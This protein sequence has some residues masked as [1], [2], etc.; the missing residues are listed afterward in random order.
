MRKC[1]KKSEIVDQLL[2][3]VT[4]AQ[5]ILIV[6]S[7]IYPLDFINYV[8]YVM[9]YVIGFL[10][11]LSLAEKSIAKHFLPIAFLGCFMLFLMGQKPFKSDYDAFLTFT[12]A[13]L[14]TE[15]YVTFASILFFGLAGMYYSYMCFSGREN[16]R[17]REFTAVNKVVLERIL[18]FFLI[19]TFPFA[20]YMQTKIVLVKS[21]MDYTAGYLVN[22]EVPTA[23]KIGSYLYEAVVLMYLAMKPKKTRMFFA[24][25][26]YL[27][28]TG[29]LQLLQGRRALFAATL[30]FTMWYLLKYFN[31]QKINK[32]TFFVLTSLVA[33]MVVIFIVVEQTR[34]GVEQSLSL[35]MV[36]NFLTSTG[37]SDSVIANTII[38]KGEFP[39]EG[40]L[41]LLDPFINNF[42][43]NILQGKA[44]V[45]QGME[46][47][48]QHNSFSHWLSYLTEQSLYLSG[49]GMGSSYLAE[50]YLAFGMIGVILASL[51]IGWT[52]NKINNVTLDGHTVG[53]AFAFFF[54]RRIFTIPRDSMFSWVG[55][56]L[57]LL[58]AFALVGFV[59]L[60]WHQKR[61]KSTLDDGMA[62]EQMMIS[63]ECST[64]TFGVIAYNEHAYLPDL[65]QNLLEQT[66][67]KELI[68]VI[69][70][71]GNSTDDTKQIMEDF[72]AAHLAEYRA[73]K[74]LD[75]PKRVQ[76]A[77]WNVVIS[78]SD[79]DVILRIDAHAK[80]PV[81]FV[82]KNIACINSGEYV[83]GGPRE[84]VI[85]E[86][87]PWKRMLLDAEQSLFGSGVASYRRE[88]EEKKYV[89]SV[90]HGAYRREVFKNAGV[91]NEQLI[92]TEDNE[93]H[94]RI[95]KHGYKICYDPSIKSYYET[96]NTLPRMLKQKYQNGLW[97]GRTLY[98][99][100][101][102]VS[103]FHLIPF[104]FVC[105]L[106]VCL[107]LAFL[108]LRWMLALLLGAYLVFVAINMISCVFKTKNKAD[109]LLPAVYFLMHCAYGVGTICGLLKGRV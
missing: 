38:R 93:I 96:R 98:T 94:Y 84:N 56:M 47:I 72:R 68:E 27:L 62:Q 99:C 15:Q 19:I 48:M 25:G 100:P 106:S 13:Q 10:A 75:N 5:I 9:N 52:I 53:V 31:I 50:V 83:C 87:T 39:Q 20:L 102:C 36:K 8:M 74:V 85:D 95:R 77:G 37:G 18:A 105:A 69:L 103:V 22:V 32:K 97:I 79:A 16:G 6:V 81:D 42:A 14:N 92:R 17:I 70:V 67:P 101:G 57:Y 88:T 12:W 108:G 60:I 40:I 59:Y 3:C 28:V 90:F 11:M 76:P 58:F 30:L 49:H 41:Y 2:F 78:N 54:A 89:N 63:E 43:G 7:A 1:I 91:F 71:D 64:I 86:D 45:P 80:L 46:Y 44:S 104:A 35:E 82:E 109:L 4:V 21:S 33:A 61:Q 26:T 73:I 55:D 65:L 24:L 23:V 34:D 107:L 66:Y 51:G 29:G